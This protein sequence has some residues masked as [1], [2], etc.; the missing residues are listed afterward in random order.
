[1]IELI[2]T[3][4][5][6]AALIEKVRSPL[7]GAVCLFL[8]TVRELTD[9]RRTESLDYQAYPEMARK[10]LEKLEADARLRWPLEEVAIS[11]RFGRLGLGEVS[12]A[13]AVSSP[14]RRDAFA[15]CQWLMD[16]IKQVVPIWK[17]ENWSDGTSEWVH[18]GLDEGG[19]SSS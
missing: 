8:G 11:H 19:A 7:A 6:H 13:V 14:H 17:Q 4:I 18:P 5:D 15:A 12:V 3:E 9:G 10:T 1:M 2:E 16:T